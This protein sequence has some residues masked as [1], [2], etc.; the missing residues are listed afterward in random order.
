MF[1]FT[2]RESARNL[3]P[4]IGS[5]ENKL[6]IECSLKS[7]VCFVAYNQQQNS[8]ENGRKWYMS[9][10]SPAETGLSFYREWDFPNLLF[11]AWQFSLEILSTL[12]LWK[13]LKLWALWEGNHCFIH[14]CLTPTV[15]QTHCTKT[16][17]LPHMQHNSSPFGNGCFFSCHCDITAGLSWTAKRFTFQTQSLHG[18]PCSGISAMACIGAGA[19]GPSVSEITA[20]LSKNHPGWQPG[21]QQG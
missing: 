5:A 13:S 14:A 15:T 3:L 6:Q 9:S 20:L 19:G 17:H 7:W 10:S 2:A 1:I 12:S 16:P 11:N 4:A 18:Y 21:A 8:G